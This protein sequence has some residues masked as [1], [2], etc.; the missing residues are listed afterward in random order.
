MRFS[1]PR[2]TLAVLGATAMLGTGSFAATVALVAVAPSAGATTVSTQAEFRDAW[3]NDA[4]IT[5]AN[6]ITLTCDG[7]RAERTSDDNF[8]LDGQGHTVTQTCPSNGVMKVEGDEGE[9][10]GQIR[11]ITITGGAEAIAGEHGGGFY[12]DSDGSLTVDNTAFLNNS[13][14]A[15]GGGLDYEGDDLTISHSTLAANVASG[16]GG[17]L[18]ASGDS[19]V[20]IDSTISGNQATQAGALQTVSTDLQLGYVTLVQN[21]IAGGPGCD[22][23]SG[24]TPTGVGGPS[25]HVSGQADPETLA[26]VNIGDGTLTSFGSVVAL[27]SAGETNCLLDALSPSQGYNFS[28]DA[29]CGF[30]ATGDRE[31]AG[32]PGLGALGANGGLAPT[33]VPQTGSP[34]LDAIPVAACA[35]GVASGV[36]DDERSVTRPQGTGCDIGAVE[37]EVIAPA[38]LVIAPRFTG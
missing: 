6:D 24:G 35:T 30:T 33:Q 29:S 3:A 7:G 36:T 21:S 2:K 20:M 31:N 18:W 26:Q 27:P 13:T 9:P 14:C 5:L 4:E 16:V 32:D 37:V 19:V 12:F 10:N 25:G 23:D 28:D 17:A 15:D 8:V 1:T 38:P 34:L 22:G 11:N